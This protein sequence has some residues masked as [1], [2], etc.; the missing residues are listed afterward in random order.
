LDYLARHAGLR[1]RE[2]GDAHRKGVGN[3]GEQEG[4]RV[5]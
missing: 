5:K 1:A 3:E 2:A 4:C